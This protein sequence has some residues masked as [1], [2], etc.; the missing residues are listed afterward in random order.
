PRLGPNLVLPLVEGL[1]KL[2]LGS[3]FWDELLPGFTVV[4]TGFP[5]NLPGSPEI[6]TVVQR[7]LEHSSERSFPRQLASLHARTDGTTAKH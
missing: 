5:H 2:I 6:R 7:Q 1:H 4:L 3:I